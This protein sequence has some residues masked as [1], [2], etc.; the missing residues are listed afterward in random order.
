MNISSLLRAAHKRTKSSF[1]SRPIHIVLL[2][3]VA[4]VMILYCKRW[5]YLSHRHHHHPF[6]NNH[7]LF[8]FT[9]KISRWWSSR[10]EERKKKVLLVFRLFHFFLALRVFF[11]VVYRESSSNGQTGERASHTYTSNTQSWIRFV[12]RLILQSPFTCRVFFPY[13]KNWLLKL[14]DKFSRTLSLYFSRLPR[15][16]IA[17]QQQQKLFLLLNVKLRNVQKALG[18]ERRSQK[19]HTLKIDNETLTFPSR[20][21]SVLLPPSSRTGVKVIFNWKHRNKGNNSSKKTI[22]KAL[23]EC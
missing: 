15:T 13:W 2:P 17:F 16:A 19:S 23:R 22:N 18:S 12:L 11:S 3:R 8:C 20:F 5:P 10:E 7:L 4:R 9:T 14:S 1:F 21:F 6:D